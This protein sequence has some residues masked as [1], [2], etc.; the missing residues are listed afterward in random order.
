MALSTTKEGLTM[1]KL[2][3]G[4]LCYDDDMPV[5]TIGAVMAHK[6]GKQPE[7]KYWTGDSPT[8]CD[9]CGKQLRAHW[10]DGKTTYGPWGNMCPACHSVRGCGLGLGKGQ[11]YDVATGEKLEG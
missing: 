6:R 5:G 2:V 3:N 1:G 10:I 9:L 4:Q 8:H 11:L 7:K